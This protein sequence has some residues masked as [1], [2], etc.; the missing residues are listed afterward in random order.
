MKQIQRQQY[1]SKKTR[2]WLKA[3]LGF[4]MNNWRRVMR[5]VF[6]RSQIPTHVKI[7][8]SMSNLAVIYLDFSILEWLDPY[9]SVIVC[10]V[11]YI[12]SSTENTHM[13]RF[14]RGKI[15]WYN[16]IW[17]ICIYIYISIYIIYLIYKIKITN[18]PMSW[19]R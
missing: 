13:I 14:S 17:L 6:V 3:D 16:P 1:P 2:A 7:T 4:S 9:L 12:D 10:P 8:F 15:I 18:F 11:L 19:L 5:Q